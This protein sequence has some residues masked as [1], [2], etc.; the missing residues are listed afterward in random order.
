MSDVILIAVYRLLGGTLF[1]SV[2]FFKN[3][4]INIQTKINKTYE[5]SVS[6]NLIQIYKGRLTT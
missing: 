6:I 1:L 5:D 4:K 3:M 2:T